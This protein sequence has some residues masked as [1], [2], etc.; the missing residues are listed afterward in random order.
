MPDNIAQRIE[1]AGLKPGYILVV[2]LFAV[3]AMEFAIRSGAGEGWW[4]RAGHA[5]DFLLRVGAIGI[6]IGFF[7]CFR[8][9]R[10]A[11]REMFR[12]PSHP[13][14]MA[15]F[16]LALAVAYAWGLGVHHAT[17]VMP[18]V[19][20]ERDY[21]FPFWGFIET[22]RRWL[23]GEW[24]LLAISMGVLTPII[25]ELFYRGMLL[26]AWRARRPLVWAVLLSSIVFGLVH[27]RS[28]ILAAGIG[29]VLALVYLRYRSLWPAIALHGIYNILQITPGLIDFTQKKSLAEVTHFSAWSV[30]IAL[31]IA[32]FPL[33]AIFWRRFKPA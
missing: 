3:F 5:R 24:V 26:N 21:F 20:V 31:A 32:F 28:A 1:A 6:G 23:P 18:S 19:F 27:G 25:E 14:S 11:M 30:E 2:L 16:L 7:A 9:L 12:R 33:A 29:A 4:D 15:D 8:D 17:I 13:V 22:S 10:V